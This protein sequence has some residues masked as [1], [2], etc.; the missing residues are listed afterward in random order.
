MR[1][2]AGDR[3]IDAARDARVPTG[4]PP[5]ETAEQAKRRKLRQAAART[6][7]YLNEMRRGVRAP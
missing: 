1:A 6:K 2:P 4:A 5:E 3:G 7:S